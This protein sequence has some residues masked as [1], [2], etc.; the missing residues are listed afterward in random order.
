[1]QHFFFK[2]KNNIGLFYMLVISRAVRDHVSQYILF[3][4]TGTDR[5]SLRQAAS[6]LRVPLHGW[7]T[8]F[9]TLRNFQA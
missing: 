5:L 9:I 1:M 8:T 4:I 2:E 3:L 6:S 7:K